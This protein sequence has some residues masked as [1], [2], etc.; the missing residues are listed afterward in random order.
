M[1]ESQQHPH[2]VQQHPPTAPDPETREE[3][4]AR[5]IDEADEVQRGRAREELVDPSTRR[6]VN[7]ALARTALTA[8]A[9]GFVAGAVIALIL[10][11]VPGPFETSGWGDTIG[12]MAGIGA[13][14]ALVVGVLASLALL[15]REDGR[16][17]RDVER[18]TGRT[19]DEPG[20]GSPQDPRYDI[21]G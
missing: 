5:V 14:L 8:A 15:A 4:V 13:A 12:Y 18:R 1:M 21:D 9:I 2:S 11:L 6:G 16:V 7:R 19:G 3:T 10:S 17:E 20:P